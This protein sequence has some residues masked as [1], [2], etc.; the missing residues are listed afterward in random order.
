MDNGYQDCT[1]CGSTGRVVDVAGAEV[2]CPVCEGFGMRFD[3]TDQETALGVLMF[4]LRLIF[5]GSG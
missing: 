1:H 3:D 4:F 2:V 5:R